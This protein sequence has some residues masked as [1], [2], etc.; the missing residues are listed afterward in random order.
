M[1]DP[2]GHLGYHQENLYTLRT[3]QKRKRKKQRDYFQKYW[4][5][6]SKFRERKI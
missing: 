2:K 5:K 3:S 1:T 4:P 6:V